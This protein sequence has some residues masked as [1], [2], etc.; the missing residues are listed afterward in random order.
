MQWKNKCLIKQIISHSDPRRN[1]W[2]LNCTGHCEGCSKI[3]LSSPEILHY[4]WG[5]GRVRSRAGSVVDWQGR[6]T[7]SADLKVRGQNRLPGKET[8]H[9]A[10]ERHTG[11]RV[12]AWCIDTIWSHIPHQR[13]T[14]Y[15]TSWGNLSFGYG[16][17]SITHIALHFCNFAPT[18]GWMLAYSVTHICSVRTVCMSI[19]ISCQSLAFLIT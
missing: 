2:Q 4:H 1:W 3:C 12:Y 19:R 18:L 6:Q 16:N 8:A 7:V 15:W 13:I 10:E 14:K 17:I 5:S 9:L 11:D